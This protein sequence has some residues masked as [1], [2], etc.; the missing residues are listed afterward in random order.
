MCNKLVGQGARVINVQWY[1]DPYSDRLYG[2]IAYE[3]ED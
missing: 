2:L 3:T 1:T